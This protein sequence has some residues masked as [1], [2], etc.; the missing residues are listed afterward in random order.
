MLL[1]FVSFCFFGLENTLLFFNSGI[2]EKSDGHTE[3]ETPREP[4]RRQCCR[5]QP[6]E[7]TT[8]SLRP[9]AGC[10]PPLTQAMTAR[11]DHE[12]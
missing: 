5:A 2:F 4:V 3:G 12:A 8:G 10:A 11:S 6:Q 7:Q 9:G 1:S